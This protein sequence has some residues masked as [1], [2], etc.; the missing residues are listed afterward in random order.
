MDRFWQKNAKERK[1]MSQEKRA[2]C[3]CPLCPSYNRCARDNH[4]LIYCIA[5][6]SQLCI[7]D[8][9]G[10]TCINCP[11]TRQMGLKHDCFCIKGGEAAQR[12]AQEQH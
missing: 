2:A 4:E 11:V 5:G 12:Y 3:T 9:Q 10:C 6:K 7:T 1:E 8:G